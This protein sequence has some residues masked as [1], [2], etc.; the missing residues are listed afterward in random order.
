M[1]TNALKPVNNICNFQYKP[2]LTIRKTMSMEIENFL[3]KT[4]KYFSFK[5]KN[6][7]NQLSYVGV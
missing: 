1:H 4:A 5:T 3:T 2:Y 7:Y 6:V